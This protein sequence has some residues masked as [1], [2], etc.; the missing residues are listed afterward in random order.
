M[1]TILS[2]RTR[3]TLQWR[4]GLHAHYC[5]ELRGFKFTVPLYAFTAVDCIEAG[6]VWR[7]ADPYSAP[8]PALKVDIRAPPL[9]EQILKT[10]TSQELVLQWCKKTYRLV[11]QMCVQPLFQ[12]VAELPRYRVSLVSTDI[13][14]LT[15]GIRS[16]KCI[17]R[18]F[19]CC[20][21]VH[22]PR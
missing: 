4:W 11:L 7:I 14:R 16:E 8:R 22:K 17:V 21:I 12:S 5:P 15:T 1:L 9:M 13:R 20:A 6:S 19:R 18:R 2:E 3:L 10:R